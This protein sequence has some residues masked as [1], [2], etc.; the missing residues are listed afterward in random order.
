MG[1]S[2][3]IP[4]S[5]KSSSKKE[6]EL[7]NILYNLDD[8]GAEIKQILGEIFLPDFYIRKN[9]IVKLNKHINEKQ[10]ENKNLDVDITDF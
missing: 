5:F 3:S 7:Y 1:K 9:K 8:R 10:E 6:V 2:L 4:I